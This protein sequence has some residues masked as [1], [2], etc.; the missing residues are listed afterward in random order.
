[1]V[2]HVVIGYV[3]ERWVF[4][5]QGGTLLEVHRDDGTIDFGRLVH[6][7]A[8][9]HLTVQLQGPGAVI[10]ALFDIGKLKAELNDSIHTQLRAAHSEISP[11]YEHDWALIAEIEHRALLTRFLPPYTG[12]LR[13][14]NSRPVMAEA[15]SHSITIAPSWICLRT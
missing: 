2:W 10:R 4:P 6:W 12:I 14:V 8:G 15:S 3:V 11:V 7:R 1:M 5:K 13:L 9:N